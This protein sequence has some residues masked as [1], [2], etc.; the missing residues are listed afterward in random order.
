[1]KNVMNSHKQALIV[2]FAF[3]LLLSAQGL[4][5]QAYIY[6]GYNMEGDTLHFAFP[7]PDS[8]FN[9]NRI[10][11]KFL[12]GVLDYSQLCYTCDSIV[13]MRTHQKGATPQGGTRTGYEMDYFG[14]CIDYL[15]NQRFDLDIILDPVVRT[16]LQSHG[17][18]YLMRMTAANPC[19]DTL[20]ISRFNDTI[21]ITDYNM[22]I[23][24][25]NN[26]TSVIPT[27]TDLYFARKFLHNTSVEIA[28]PDY[29]GKQLAEVILQAIHTLPERTLKD[30]RQV[31]R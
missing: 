13:E 31:F 28:E 23:A 24:Y 15:M 25:F 27:L 29:I 16:I 5:A 10:G 22:M 2:C 9:H 30:R 1:M 19:V 11:M 6:N 26:D 7:P 18:T 8:T 12:T 14:S 20:S 3:V 17:V 4:R 21:K